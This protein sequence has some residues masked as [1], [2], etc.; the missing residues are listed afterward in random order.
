MCRS[1][2]K[3]SKV[4]KSYANTKYSTQIVKGILLFEKILLEIKKYILTLEFFV[5]P[6]QNIFFTSLIFWKKF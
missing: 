3:S 5:S 4:L 1:W 2:W 6:K